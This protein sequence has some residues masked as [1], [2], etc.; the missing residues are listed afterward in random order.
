M[1]FTINLKVFGDIGELN[2]AGK[3]SYSV[4]RSALLAT[5]DD[6]FT[7][8]R[9]RRIEANVL[10]SDT[11]ARRALQSAGF[12]LE[13]IR[14]QGHIDFA[15]HAVDIA[16]YA[17]LAS[18]EIDSRI[19]NTAVL[20][21]VLPK[22]RILA[23]LLIQNQLDQVLVCETSYSDGYILPGGIVELGETP[24][25]AVIR[26][27]QEELGYTP[28]VG[29]LLVVDWL[30]PYLGW[31]DALGLIFDGGK[32]DQAKTTVILPA[33]SEIL[34][35]HWLS[36]KDLIAKMTPGWGQRSVQALA[37]KAGILKN[38]YL[39]IGIQKFNSF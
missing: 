6:A 22:K 4:L 20:N 8:R 29:E 26:E 39:E 17:R 10:A 24:R 9:L 27:C 15:N 11:T 36:S 1:D 31:E 35:L 5:A 13:G 18:D 38:R 34:A 2:W 19:A 25:L 14:R 28:E 12:R 21:T 32:L 23:H 30:A 16:L 37:A 33:D 3:F 7:A